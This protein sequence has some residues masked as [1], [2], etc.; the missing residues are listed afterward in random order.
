MN[1]KFRQKFN[2]RQGH[3]GRSSLTEYQA[4]KLKTLRQGQPINFPDVNG[5]E[6]I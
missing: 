6:G 1:P 2:E 4:A 5:T 3:L